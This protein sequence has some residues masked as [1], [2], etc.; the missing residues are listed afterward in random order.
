[1]A[2]LDV[3][4]KI[5]DTGYREP[6]PE[7]DPQNF[8]KIVYSR[9][10]VRVFSAVHAIPD[11]VV[12]KCLDIA[13]AAPNSSNLQPW[14][15]YWVKDT[16]KLKTLKEYCVSQSAAVTA[17]TIIVAVAKLD[18]WDRNRKMMIDFFNRQEKRPPK[19]A[20]LYYEKLAKLSYSQ[21]PLGLFG[22][23]KQILFFF[24]R[25]MGQVIAQPP[26]SKSDMRVW[27]HKS[28]ALACENLMLAF[29]A[30]GYDSCPME[31]LDPKRIKK[32][33]NLSR[34][35]EICMAVSAG[36]RAPNGIFSPRVRFDRNLFVKKI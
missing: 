34:G 7:V 28:T 25:L 12:D 18:T 11:E 1:M 8:E 16:E 17:P 4:R 14:E 21:G 36:K 15:F 31:G 27:A 6:T 22:L 23:V 26:T 33:L 24:Q 3:L 10:S 2:N 29:R 19:G 5:P 32:L 35:S 13:L 9:R 20:Y 30:Y